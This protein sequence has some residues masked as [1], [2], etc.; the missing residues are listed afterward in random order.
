[1]NTQFPRLTGLA[2][3]LALTIAVPAAEAQSSGTARRSAQGRTARAIPKPEVVEMPSPNHNSR[4]GAAIDTIVLHHTADGGK[5][6]DTGRYFQNPKSQVS[7][8]YIVGKDGVIVQSVADKDRAWHA[9]KSAFQGRND[10]N[11]FSIGIEIVNRGDSKDPFTDAQ[12]EALGRL[13][14]Y[15]QSQ[16]NVPRDRITGHKDVA[17]PKGRKID[18][19]PNFLYERLDQELKKHQNGK[20]RSRR[21]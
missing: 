19:A 2:T 12:Y 15:L 13:V 11:T 5:A 16:Y 9:G 7:S 1:M 14:A 21:S 4:N 8:H 10:V 20:P 18:P 3:L 6:Q 17:L